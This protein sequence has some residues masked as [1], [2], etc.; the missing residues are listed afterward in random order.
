MP[1]GWYLR[2]EAQHI[3]LSHTTTHSVT[4]HSAKRTLAVSRMRRISRW[5][6]KRLSP[7]FCHSTRWYS[8]ALPGRGCVCAS[9]E[10]SSSLLE[11]NYNHLKSLARRAGVVSPRLGESTEQLAISLGYCET[12]L[13][14]VTTEWQSKPTPR[15]F[16]FSLPTQGRCAFVY[17][18]RLQRN[19]SSH[20]GPEGV[21]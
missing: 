20:E 5:N 6:T 17:I 16:H 19:R 13:V 1:I 14:L 21:T 3:L 4:Q 11:P 15:L 18:L 7:V 9:T 10:L 8:P 2:A 12:V